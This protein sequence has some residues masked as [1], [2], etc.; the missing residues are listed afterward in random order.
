MII[1][2]RAF[3]RRFGSYLAGSRDIGAGASKRDPSQR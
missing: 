3:R 1:T 2:Y